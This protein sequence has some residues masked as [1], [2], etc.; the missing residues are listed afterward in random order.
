MAAFKV[1]GEYEKIVVAFIVGEI[2]IEIAI[3]MPM[4]K[5]HSCSEERAI[6]LHRYLH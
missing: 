2:V 1:V 3:R 6:I 4:R 5:S